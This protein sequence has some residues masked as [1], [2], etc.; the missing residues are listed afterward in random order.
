MKNMQLF[1]FDSLVWL[2][3]RKRIRETG[4]D[5]IWYRALSAF[6]EVIKSRNEKI[7]W[8]LSNLFFD[9][10]SG[11]GLDLWG[12]RYRISRL[13]EESDTAYKDRI[14][15]TLS[16]RR[17]P[18][19]IAN[20]RSICI[21]ILECGSEEVEVL[22]VYN[23]YDNWI[24]GSTIATRDYAHHAYRIYIPKTTMVKRELLK[25]A[26]DTITIGGN[27]PEVWEVS[28]EPTDIYEPRLDAGPF[29]EKQYYR[30]Y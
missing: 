16:Y 29:G 30:V 8:L 7:S 2:N 17:K 24:M 6:L 26:I 25:R 3:Q 15:F 5:G 28:E 4:Q 1:D 21:S 23:N 18:G 9:T 27:Y 22:E 11:R 13:V 19:T 20:V 14:R 12:A 10:S